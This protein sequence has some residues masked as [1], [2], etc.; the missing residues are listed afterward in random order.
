[1]RY[2]PNGFGK[3]FPQLEK[4]TVT[5]GL[6]S[7][8]AADF[9]GLANL[10]E[11]YIEINDI[12]ELSSDLF[13]FTPE[14]SVI[15]FTSNNISRV[16]KDLLKNLN[17][18]KHVDFRCNKCIDREKTSDLEAVKKELWIKCADP[19]EIEQ[20]KCSKVLENY[21]NDISE[22]EA[23]RQRYVPTCFEVYDPD[24]TDLIQKRSAK[25]EECRKAEKC[26][27]TSV[28]NFLVCNFF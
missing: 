24:W 10:K 19:K 16:G 20:E 3:F 22:L 28:V 2:F 13:K 18:L 14:L 11:L 26:N 17:S 12:D 23:E 4:L 6:K 1:M 21:E 9:E 15:S 5:F 27:S 8:K 25:L 7:I